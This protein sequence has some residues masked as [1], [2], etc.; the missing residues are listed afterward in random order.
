MVM[1]GTTVWG[2]S[3]TC[4]VFPLHFFHRH[5]SKR[6]SGTIKIYLNKGIKKLILLNIKE[7]ENAHLLN[8]YNQNLIE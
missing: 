3:L 5:T 7:L 4:I 8:N 6:I 2:L 1:D